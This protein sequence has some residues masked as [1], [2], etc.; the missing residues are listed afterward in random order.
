MD[1]VLTRPSTL[2]TSLSLPCIPSSAQSD[3]TPGPYTVHFVRKQ[4]QADVR[5]LISNDAVFEGPETFFA[6]L[7]LSPANPRRASAV[8]PS[9]AEITIFD[10]S[11]MCS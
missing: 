4:T 1:G 6:N 9:E 8:D 7:S 2:I 3:Y 11:G 10:G 5:I